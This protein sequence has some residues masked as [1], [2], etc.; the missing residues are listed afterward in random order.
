V[1][2]IPPVSSSTDAEAAHRLGLVTNGNVQD[3]ALASGPLPNSGGGLAASKHAPQHSDIKKRRLTFLGIGKKRA[4]SVP[5]KVSRSDTVGSSPR[6]PKLQRKT[7]PNTLSQVPEDSW[8][9]PLPPKIGAIADGDDRPNTSDGMSP[10]KNG[11]VRPEIGK[12]RSTVDEVGPAQRRVNFST[13]PIYSQK[14][15]RKKKFPTLRRMFGL[16]D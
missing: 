11:I 5:A 6:S 10:Q 13:E 1:P 12:R 9:L 16:N 2:A 8:P 4:S 7:G 3:I 15:G 14:T